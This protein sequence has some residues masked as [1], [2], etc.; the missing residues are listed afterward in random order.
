MVNEYIFESGG[1]SKTKKQ[2]KE[3]E[4]LLNFRISWKIIS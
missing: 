1:K 3:I 4:G 2:I